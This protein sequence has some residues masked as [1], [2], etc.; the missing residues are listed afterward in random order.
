MFKDEGWLSKI[1]AKG[2]YCV[3]MGKDIMGEG[4]EVMPPIFGRKT[5]YWKNDRTLKI[6]EISN[7]V[8]YAFFL[9]NCNY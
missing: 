7:V 2:K 1:K 4:K 3:M 9:G 6:S 8:S 5:I